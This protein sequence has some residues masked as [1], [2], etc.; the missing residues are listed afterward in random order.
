G[1]GTPGAHVAQG[2]RRAHQA[3]PIEVAALELGAATAE[4][5]FVD[6]QTHPGSLPADPAKLLGVDDPMDRFHSALA[7]GE[8]AGHHHLAVGPAHHETGQA[9]DVAHLDH[10]RTELARADLAQE[11]DHPVATHDRVTGGLAVGAAIA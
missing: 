8:R 7:D 11:A 2:H 9:V 10:R 4:T 3:A 6:L 1:D 5:G